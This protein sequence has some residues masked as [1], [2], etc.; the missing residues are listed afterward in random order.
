MG[1][2]NMSKKKILLASL[3]ILVVVA[4]LALVFDFTYRQTSSI[5][6]SLLMTAIVSF[7]ALIIALQ[8]K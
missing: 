1:G 6:K 7:L 2:E 8:R 3:I 4:C 5:Q